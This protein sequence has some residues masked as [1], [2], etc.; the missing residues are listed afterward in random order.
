MSWEMAV[1]NTQYGRE[2]P[3]FPLVKDKNK[4]REKQST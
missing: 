1:N 2:Q 3:Y 4:D